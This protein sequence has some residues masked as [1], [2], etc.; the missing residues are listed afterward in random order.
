MQRRVRGGQITDVVNY[1][2]VSGAENF[3][4]IYIDTFNFG[5]VLLPDN[6]LELD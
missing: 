1:W 3:E 4:Y 2:R 6:T 5:F